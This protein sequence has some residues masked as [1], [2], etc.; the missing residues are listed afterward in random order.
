[1]IEWKYI[2]KDATT[3]SVLK[4]FHDMKQI[5]DNT[6]PEIKAYCS[7][8]FLKMGQHL[9]YGYIQIDVQILRFLQAFEY[10]HWVDPAWKSLP[11]TERRIL[12]EYYMTGNVRSG[13]SARLQQ[14]LNYSDRQIERMRSISLK[15]LA[16]LLF[17]K[18]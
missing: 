16:T 5:Y 14:L 7:S 13:A 17:G 10:I 4:D 3:I 2:D 9:F 12:Y 1:M 11:E 8:C 15:H 18:G 6:P